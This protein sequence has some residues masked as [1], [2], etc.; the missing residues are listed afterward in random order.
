MATLGVFAAAGLVT[1][2]LRATLI[3]F[4]PSRSVA[5]RLA[6]VFRYAAPA[7]FASMAATSVAASER[8][9]NGRWQLDVAVLLTGVAAWRSKN[10]AITIVVGAAAT[11][12]LSR[13]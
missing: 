8:A 1:W 5:A 7:A 10:L 6:R 2:L 12:I 13:F 4:V 11:T 9:G 3:V